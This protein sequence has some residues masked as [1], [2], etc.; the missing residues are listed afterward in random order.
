MKYS[1]TDFVNQDDVMDG[2][3]QIAVD[4]YMLYL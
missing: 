2:L 3:R 1:M 4:G